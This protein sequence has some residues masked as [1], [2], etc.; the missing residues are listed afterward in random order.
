MKKS[1]NFLFGRD[2][3]NLFWRVAV[4]LIATTVREQHPR[5][6]I[7][8]IMEQNQRNGL[9]QEQLLSRRRVCGVTRYLVRWR[10]HTSADDEWFTAATRWRS[11]MPLAPVVVRVAGTRRRCCCRRPDAPAVAARRRATV[12]RLWCHLHLLPPRL[13][14]SLRP[15]SGFRIPPR[16]PRTPP[17][18]AGRCCTGGPAM[19]AS[20]FVRR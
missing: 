18:W 12:A 15:A 16:W 19:A 10:G 20:G 8:P 13:W 3:L 2:L 4:A 17:H 14:W 5:L 6:A 7:N 9:E 1:R 11:I